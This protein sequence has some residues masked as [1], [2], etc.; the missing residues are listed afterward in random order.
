MCACVET[1]AP[2]SQRHTSGPLGS[3]LVSCFDFWENPWIHG[4]GQPNHRPHFPPYSWSLPKPSHESTAQG[5]SRKYD[6]VKADR[7][8]EERWWLALSFSAKSLCGDSK[9][10]LQWVAAT[11]GVVC[12][13]QSRLIPATVPAQ[14]STAS[15]FTLERISH[16]KMNSV[17]PQPP[18]NFCW[19]LS[20]EN[21][22]SVARSYQTQI[23]DF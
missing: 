4:G 2:S 8:C 1:G 3:P 22:L 13:A 12:P 16:W 5:L 11:L 7:K 19:V 10:C 21:C 18:F 20:C 23:L 15:P 17:A 9:S 6:E 14:F